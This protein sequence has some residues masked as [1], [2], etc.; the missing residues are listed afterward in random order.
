M[1][2]GNKLIREGKVGCVI[3]AGGQ[4]SRLGFDGPKGKYDIGLPSQKSLFQIL[5]ERF[6][7]V[8]LNAHEQKI[9]V[10]SQYNIK[11]RKVAE[12]PI[13]A[14]TCILFIMTSYENHDETVS[15]FRENK[16]FGGHPDSFVFFPQ[17]M[18]PAVDTEGKIMMA[19][20]SSLKLAPN[21]NGALFDSLKSN[22]EVQGLIS[23]LEYVQ[24]IGVD[25]A[26]NKVLDPVQIGFTHN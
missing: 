18:L 11:G 16:F 25:N 13:E 7:R 6:L 20:P 12:V 26:L 15:F 8:Q 3:L 4:G 10:R 24:I 21:G 17:S 2:A 5:T 23:T 19:S 9:R 22:R 1:T 14:Q